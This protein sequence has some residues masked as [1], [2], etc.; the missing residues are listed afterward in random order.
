M[1]FKKHDFESA[2]I[3]PVFSTTFIMVLPK[4]LFDITTMSTVLCKDVVDNVRLHGYVTISHVWGEQKMY[5]ADELGILGGVDWKVPLSDPNKVCR[6][7]D[8]MNSHG[9]EYC[10][11]DVLCMNQDRQDEIN[12]EIPFMGDYYNGAD[13]TFVLSDNE[14]TI[15]DEYKTW[16]SMMSDV[17]ES[18]AGF[19][20][21]Q[22]EWISKNPNLL[23]FSKD[24]W[25][26][27]VWTLQETILSKKL[28]LVD[29]NRSYLDLSDLLDKIRFLSKDNISYVANAFNNSF[30]LDAA[31][32]SHSY[33]NKSLELVA[34]LGVSARRE[35]YKIH[36]KFYATLGMLGYRDFVV[37]YD[38]D[39]DDLN[40][41]IIRH[42]CS[43][44][45]VTWISTGGDIGT[46][47]I[48]PMYNALPILQGYWKQNTPSVTLHDTLHVQ[49]EMFGTV[50][51]C[52]KY[53]GDAA[54]LGEIMSWTTRVF[55]DWGFNPTQISDCMMQYA[56]V[57]TKV[58][59]VG[60]RLIKIC[61]RGVK[62]DDMS[63]ETFQL[64]S[65][66]DLLEFFCTGVICF[67]KT[68]FRGVKWEDVPRETIQLFPMPKVIERFG[69]VGNK[70]LS[71]HT[72]YRAV[73]IVKVVAQGQSYPL[74]VCGNADEGDVVIVTKLYDSS[75]SRRGLGIVI[76]KSPKRKGVCIV[77]KGVSEK[78]VD[79]Y[80]FVL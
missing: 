55:T 6:L 70:L 64:F 49:A 34:V 75:N 76:S 77:P 2:R 22:F 8:A 43:R 73:T 42:A 38:I 51:C 16:S 33:R 29:I 74:I 3:F 12:L 71:L 28:V 5:S 7:V 56:D 23:D 24:P 10:W 18:G 25:F 31:R 44:G 1:F 30:L 15:S 46:S 61:S 39:I 59:D 20:R 17:M 35:C 48:Q 62:I 78:F 4:R 65:T 41:R 32:T 63:R 80:K 47:F 72:I 57:S 14:Y 60:T 67:V 21:H 9:M 58:A 79:T 26:T 13:M 53:T 66:L 37:D 27:R 19:T 36:D 11:W 68:L 40:K 50:E 45:D 52:E 69:I 54:N